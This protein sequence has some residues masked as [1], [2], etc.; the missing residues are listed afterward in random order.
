MKLASSSSSGSVDGAGA[1]LC[2]V[3]GGG[4]RV[5]VVCRS[6]RKDG[7]SGVW[8][9]RPEVGDL[10]CHVGDVL[11][12]VFVFCSVADPG[13]LSRI[14]NPDFYPSRISDPGSKNSKKR[15]G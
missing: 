9:V 13:C 4:R 6:L 5:I 3:G 2:R 7:D 8:V 14:P 10:E 11:V 12:S 1:E 15:E